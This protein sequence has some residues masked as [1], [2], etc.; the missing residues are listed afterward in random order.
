MLSIG[1]NYSKISKF[2]EKIWEVKT[3]ENLIV[4]NLNENKIIFLNR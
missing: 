1:L 4:E 2:I 3:K